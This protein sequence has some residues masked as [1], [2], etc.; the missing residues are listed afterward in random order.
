MTA[1][2]TMKYV[3]ISLLNVKNCIN[4]NRKNSE[5]DRSTDAA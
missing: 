2:D 3:L 5:I 4:K 1:L